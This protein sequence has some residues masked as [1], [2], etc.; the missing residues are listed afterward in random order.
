MARGT[1]V[2][3]LVAEFRGDTTDLERSV[4]RSNSTIKKFS[5]TAGRSV[6]SLRGAFVAASAAA[7]AFGATLSFKGAIDTSIQLDRLNN[8]MLAATKSAG[9]AAE[10]FTF[11]DELTDRLGLSF[12]ET[13][14]GFAGFSAAALRAGLTFGE[15]KQIFEDMATASTSLQLSGERVALVF[16][17][18][19]QI[20]SK[21]VLQMEELKLQLGDSLPGA[22]EIAA[23]AMGVTSGEL[24]KMIEN[25]EVMAKDF[26]PKFG[27]AIREELG[28]SAEIAAKQLQAE[29]DRMKKSFMELQDEFADN[30]A[31]EAYKEV[32]KEMGT[33]FKD[34]AFVQAIRNVSGGI[35]Q[36]TLDIIEATKAFNEFFGITR[37]GEIAKIQN[38]INDIKANPRG[39]ILPNSILGDIEAPLREAELRQLEARLANINAIDEAKN[40]LA[41][42]RE[43]YDK[44]QESLAQQTQSLDNVTLGTGKVNK[45]TE[46]L[47]KEVKK[48]SGVLDE[49]LT[50]AEQYK[51]TLEEI[52]KITQS[53]ALAQAAANVGLTEAEARMRLINQ[54]TKDYADAM[55]EAREK[56]VR[57]KNELADFLA[58]GAQGFDSFRDAAVNALQDVLRNMLRVAMGGTAEDSLFGSLGGGLGGLISNGIGSLFGGGGFDFASQSGFKPGFFGP[59]FATGGA[60]MESRAS[61]G[62]DNQMVA[63]RKSK[64]ERLTISRPGQQNG[65]LTGGGGQTIVQQTINVSTGVQQTV[66]AEMAKFLPQI[67]KESVTAVEDALARSKLKG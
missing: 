58:E 39:S 8:K 22:L 31:G 5:T 1:V 57:S 64:N 28:G 21:G 7:A 49:I 15:T 53:G 14:D 63:L 17:A 51:E 48:A 55:E 47:T 45:E 11:L 35:A 67:K 34:P 60:V 23:R 54:A 18:L 19:E 65:G 12:V 52:E 29:T 32:I 9:L 56:T 61:G 44:Q 20:A 46:D 42:L 43:E 30:G 37:G 41:G 10:S 40:Q 66:R 38:R 36:L 59:G 6:R 62:P 2:D 25:G 50:P 13:A 27:A 24:I 3:I 26:L 33:L 4:K 16:R